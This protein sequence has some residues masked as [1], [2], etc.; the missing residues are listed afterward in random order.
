MDSIGLLLVA[1]GAF[2]IAGAV[3][4][5]DFFMNARKARLVV[6]IIGRT[7]ARIFYGLLGTIVLIAGALTTV[8]LL[9]K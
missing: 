2:A 6:A 4:D 3:M 7:G 5:W 9:Q 1:F 8:G